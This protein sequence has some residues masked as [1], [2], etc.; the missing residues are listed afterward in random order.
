[1]VQQ[2]LYLSTI[3]FAP[4]ASGFPNNLGL[5]WKAL[6]LLILAISALKL[7]ASSLL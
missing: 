5:F 4:S 7:V 1:M 6:K 2:L 3:P